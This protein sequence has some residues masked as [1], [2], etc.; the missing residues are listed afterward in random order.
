V[1]ASRFVTASQGRQEAA[2]CQIFVFMGHLE[3]TREQDELTTLAAFL[4]IF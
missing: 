4:V 3:Y 1:H 2:G